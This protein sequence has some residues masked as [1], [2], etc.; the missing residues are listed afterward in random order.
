MN[1]A[2]LIPVLVV[3]GVYGA[4]SAI[5][6]HAIRTTLKRKCPAINA[7]INSWEI[8]KRSLP[9]LTAG[10]LLSASS[11]SWFALF[12]LLLEPSADLFSIKCGLAV[13]S[14]VF[15]GWCYHWALDIWKGRQTVSGASG[16]TVADGSSP[17]V[18]SS[19]GT[20]AESEEL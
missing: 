17:T 12:G 9:M 7:W 16:T 11:P 13:F 15:S 18:D 3:I 5:L 10:V 6:T 4:A 1:A 14:G 19:D 8:L 2:S 20:D